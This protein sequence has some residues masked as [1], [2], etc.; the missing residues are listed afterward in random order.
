MK[1]LN[2]KI[3]K[4]LRER[5]AALGLSQEAVA[6]R[7]GMHANYYCNLE[8]GRRQP[9]SKTILRLVKALGCTPNDLLL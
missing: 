3:A 4:R 6:K 7:A 1:S 9:T 8:N 2:T 5:R